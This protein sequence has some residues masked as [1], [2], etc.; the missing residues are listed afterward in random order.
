MGVVGTDDP[1]LGAIESGREGVWRAVGEEHYD[2]E[3]ERLDTGMLSSWALA[4]QKASVKL[5]SPLK[6]MEFMSFS[7][8][9]LLNPL[10]EVFYRDHDIGALGEFYQPHPVRGR[11]ES[12]DELYRRSPRTDDI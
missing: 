4:S 2:P 6:V 12:V 8:D 1:W 11:I 9:D 10:A 3:V 5:V 7:I